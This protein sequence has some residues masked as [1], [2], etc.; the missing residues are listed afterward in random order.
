ML[1]GVGGHAG[2]FSNA[3]DLGILMQMYLNKG[4]YGGRQ[5]IKPETIDEYTKCQF[6]ENDNRRGA[7]FDKPTTDRSPGPSCGCTDLEAFGHQGFTGTV[8]WADPGENV[9]FVFL[10]NRIYP[11]A[12]NKKLQELNIRTDI[13]NAFYKAI[14]NGKDLAVE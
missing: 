8:T 1:G 9:V 6:C 5:Y 4:V 14:E 13:Q 7:G 10:S 12:G 11:D 2:L 3:N